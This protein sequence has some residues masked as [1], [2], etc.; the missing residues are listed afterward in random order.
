VIGGMLANKDARGFLAPFAGVVDTFVAVP[1]PGHA[2]HAPAD[3]LRVAAE[4]GIPNRLTAQDAPA[5]LAQI[6]AARPGP[7]A[8]LIV[9]SLYLAGEVLN[10]NDE[11]PD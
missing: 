11:A 4:L 7:D 5:A 6:A 3:L 8:V 10:G 1:V 9:G 2:C